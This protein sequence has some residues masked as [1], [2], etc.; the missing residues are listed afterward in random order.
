MVLPLIKQT[1]V[2]L[3]QRFKILKSIKIAVL[4]CYGDF[5]EW[6]DFAYWWSFIGKGLRQQPAQQ[7]FISLDSDTP[8]DGVALLRVL[9]LTRPPC[10]VSF[11]LN[12]KCLL[13]I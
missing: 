9:L 10:L 6:D 5:A 11:N 13:P 8:S 4:R 2:T 3:F 12:S 7:A 1:I